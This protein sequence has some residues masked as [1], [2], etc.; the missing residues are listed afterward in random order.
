M[1]SN[2]FNRMQNIRVGRKAMND[3]LIR[4]SVDK[5]MDKRLEEHKAAIWKE[6]MQYAAAVDATLLLSLHKTEGYGKIKLRRIYEDVI[7]TRVEYRLFYR[8]GSHYEE[9]IT[10]QNAEDEA[11]VKELLSI[12]VDIKA[13]EAETMDIDSKTGEVRFFKPDG[14]EVKRV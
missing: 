9:Q 8:D 14:Q 7:R 4:T 3:Y 6:M 11:I 13:W 10:G 12:G 5:Q 2:Y 1:K